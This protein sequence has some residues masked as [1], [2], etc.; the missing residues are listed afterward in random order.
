MG[1]QDLM[2]PAAFSG[3]WQRDGVSI[4][5]EAVHEPAT[6]IWLQAGDRYVDLRTSP[7]PSLLNGPRAFGGSTTFGNNTIRWAHHVDCLSDPVAAP[8]IDRDLADTGHV[9][10]HDYDT[11]SETGTVPTEDGPAAYE[12]LWRRIPDAQTG[13]S[14]SL[15]PADGEGLAVRSGRHVAALYRPDSDEADRWAA[16]HIRERVGRWALHVQLG[17]HI[18]CGRLASSLLAAIGEAHSFSEPATTKWTVDELSS[19]IAS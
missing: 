14:F 13:P 17:D 1:A 6:T 8:A 3:G 16:V 2:T 12:E 9:S 5:D 15:T 4:G 11:F 10:W 18:E 7:E 19:S